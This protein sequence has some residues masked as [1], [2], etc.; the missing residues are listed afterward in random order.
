MD[1][2]KIPPPGT[3]IHSTTYLRNAMRAVRSAGALLGA[4]ALG[5]LATRDLL[6]LLSGLAVALG[7]VFAGMSMGVLWGIATALHRA[8]ST[9][10]AYTVLQA[11]RADLPPPDENILREVYSDLLEERVS[12]A[13]GTVE[14]EIR[15]WLDGTRWT[16][17]LHP[18]NT[19]TL[20]KGDRDTP[21]SFGIRGKDGGVRFVHHVPTR[22]LEALQT[23][24]QERET[25]GAEAD[26]KDEGAG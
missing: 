23:K 25:H 14:R 21:I 10:A 6:S 26:D 11:V 1:A 9:M 4:A 20:W 12:P 3:Q 13:V 16:L 8:G 17:D 7:A 2:P 15:I 22:V 5:Y 19:A 24:S 18:G